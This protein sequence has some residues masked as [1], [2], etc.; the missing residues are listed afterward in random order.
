M[1]RAATSHRRLNLP[2]KYIIV[3]NQHVVAGLRSCSI[4]V[5]LRERE[6]GQ[7]EKGQEE[8]TEGHWFLCSAF[9]TVSVC[10]YEMTVSILV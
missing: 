8:E 1:T 5:A 7:G 9:Q 3:D 10:A 4:S 2:R 6:A